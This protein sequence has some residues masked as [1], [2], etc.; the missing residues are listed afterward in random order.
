MPRPDLIGYNKVYFYDA[1]AY[2][3]R[4]HRHRHR[5]HFSG[6]R[7]ASA[8][9]FR[10]TAART[11]ST[12]RWS[13]ERVNVIMGRIAGRPLTGTTRSAMLP[14]ARIAA[15]GGLIIALK[16]STWYMPRLLIVK[17]APA[18]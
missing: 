16:A 3:H 11:P 17:L 18:I 15:C 13:H 5:S 2:A 4:T 12:T 8:T 1:G 14:T 7:T 10:K 6:S 9:S